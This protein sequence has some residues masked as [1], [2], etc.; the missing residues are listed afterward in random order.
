MA[1]K[2]GSDPKNTGKAFRDK[3]AGRYNDNEF[4]QFE[5]SELQKKQIREW[6]KNEFSFEESVVGLVDSGYKITFKWD[7]YGSCYGVFVTPAQAD[8][9]NVGLILTGRGSVPATALA[10]ALFKHLIIFNGIWPRSGSRAKPLTW[11]AE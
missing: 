4:V 1:T 3:I 9:S 6:A 7:D 2:L 5:L 11:D 10:E 8:T